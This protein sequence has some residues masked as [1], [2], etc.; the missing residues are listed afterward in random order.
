MKDHHIFNTPNTIVSM[1]IPPDAPLQTFLPPTPAYS[2]TTTGS[3]VKRSVDL[4]S[5]AGKNV[6]IAFRHHNVTDQ[7]YLLIDD[8]TL[9]I[10]EAPN[11]TLQGPRKV[12]V[13]D[14]V[15]FTAFVDSPCTLS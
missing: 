8:I 14:T 12:R 1:W 3:W 15:V 10:V 5:Y 9:D 13:G 6:N 7:Y 11:L 2:G 4:S